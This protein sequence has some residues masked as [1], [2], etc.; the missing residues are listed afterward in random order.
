VDWSVVKLEEVLVNSQYGL[1]KRSANV[2]KY[3]ILRMMNLKDGVVDPSDLK[4]IDLEEEEY[5]KYQVRNKDILFNR[6]NS[7]DLVGRTSIFDLALNC[8]F[9]SYI[10]RLGVIEKKMN[11]YFLNYYFNS[12]FA[13][14]NLKKL[15]TKA[16]GQSNIS[17]SKLRTF[18]IPIPSLK[19]QEQIVE[20]ISR[21]EAVRVFNINKRMALETL[22]TSIRR[23][24]M[25]GETRVITLDSTRIEGVSS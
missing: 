1:S 21:I 25:T 18:K 17:A 13:Q 6:T 23:S 24:L 10:V 19:T 15:A 7:I 12:V 4:Y 2:G 9:A 14:R 8:V 20:I 11:P 22:F 3:P 16:V 5:N